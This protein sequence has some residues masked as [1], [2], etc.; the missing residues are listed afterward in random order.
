MHRF[1]VTPE[2]NGRSDVQTFLKRGTRSYR[3]AAPD[4]FIFAAARLISERAV[5]APSCRRDPQCGRLAGA[6]PMHNF[7]V[8]ADHEQIKELLALASMREHDESTARKHLSMALELAWASRAM[9]QQQSTQYA[10]QHSK[11]RAKLAKLIEKTL[12]CLQSVKQHR[13]D[14]G[15]VLHPVGSGVIDV[16]STQEM[17]C[18]RTVELPLNP[19]LTDRE[20]LL[21]TATKAIAAVNI[22]VLLR[23][24]SLRLRLTQK[25]CGQK[26]RGRPTDLAT[27]QIVLYAVSFFQKHSFVPASADAHNPGN[28][29]HQFVERFYGVVTG[30][31]IDSGALDWYIGKTM[32]MLKN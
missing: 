28:P 9:Q 20:L 19:S 30:K 2:R 22:E 10:R 7:R 18:G 26:P 12:E 6:L 5:T 8:A 4:N 25:P 23:A 29:L 27:Q 24:V 3:Y 11:Q 15:I 21:P 1:Y 17:V 13:D 16:A 31:D 14:I 32:A